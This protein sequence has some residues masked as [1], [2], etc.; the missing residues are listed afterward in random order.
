MNILLSAYSCEP[1]KGSEAA[2][3]WNWAIQLA[4]QGNNVW[5]ITRQNN[6][7]K[8]DQ[9]VSK[10]SLENLYFLYYDLPPF[11]TFWKKGRKGI[12]LYYFLWQLGILPIVKS[13]LRK[14]DIDYIH[15]V[16]FATFRQPSFLGLLGLPFIFGPVAGAENVPYS[17]RIK[18]PLK[19]ILNEIARDVL[20]F[21][22]KIDPLM[23]I[24]FMSSKVIF[25]T[26]EQTKHSI[27]F[28]YHHKTITQIAIGIE[29]NLISNKK[30]SSQANKRLNLLY[31]G[32][33]YCWKGVHVAL[34]SLQ[35]L[36]Q[37]YPSAKL[38]IVGSGCDETWLK[39]LS[40]TLGI[41]S[42]IVWV[43]WISREKVMDIYA[44]HD[45]FIFPSHRDSGGIVILEALS[46]GIPVICLNVGGPGSI[47]DETC[48]FSLDPKNLCFNDIVKQIASLI[49]TYAS[50]QQL[51]D[52]LSKGALLRAKEYSWPILTQRITTLINKI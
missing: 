32:N 14:V 2:L 26:S 27:P 10:L 13:L 30:S 19:G 28:F 17:M 21:F 5:V 20:N 33:L 4:S 49:L 48:G 38:T 31:V 34:L 8:I 46:Q 47:V 45:I 11:L 29:E 25:V 12:Y 7:Q 50:S 37:F 3:G 51:Q 9:M 43:P 42:N 41:D 52:I 15:H 40:L 35:S 6:K 22:V 18:Y 16:S 23:H 36:I 24:T 39:K 44:D 1:N